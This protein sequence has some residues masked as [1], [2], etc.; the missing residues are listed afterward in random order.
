MTFVPNRPLCPT[1]HSAWPHLHPSPDLCTD[2]YHQPVP[3]TAAE[4]REE[5]K[6]WSSLLSTTTTDEDLGMDSVRRVVADMDREIEA[7][8]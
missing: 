5:V 1:C 6:R 8:R 3:T 7:T 4:W 2:P